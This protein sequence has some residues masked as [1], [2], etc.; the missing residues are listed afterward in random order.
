[1]MQMALSIMKQCNIQIN[2]IEIILALI[3]FLSI[4]TKVPNT[5]VNYIFQWI[6]DNSGPPHKSSLWSPVICYP[7]LFIKKN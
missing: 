4:R 5:T 6:L 7:I 1:M 3:K 2:T